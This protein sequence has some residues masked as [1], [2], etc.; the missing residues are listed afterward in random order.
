MSEVETIEQE[1]TT[2]E[3]RVVRKS[4]HWDSPKRQRTLSL[5]DEV[6][7]YISSLAEDNKLNRSEVIE[8]IARRAKWTKRNLV[9][10]RRDLLS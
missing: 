7:K 4:H 5:T 2:R 6:W 8:I 1:I 10:D 3:M 9:E